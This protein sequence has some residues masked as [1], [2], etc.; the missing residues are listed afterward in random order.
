MALPI[1][2]SLCR[3]HA[4]GS[5]MHGQNCSY[6]H[7]EEMIGSRVGDAEPISPE[8]LNDWGYEQDEPRRVRHIICKHWQASDGGC[9]KG[10]QC[11]FAH[12]SNAIGSKEGEPNPPARDRESEDDDGRQVRYKLCRDWKNYQC[13]RGD[14]CPF[15]HGFQ[16]INTKAGDPN[17]ESEESAAPAA[18]L[19]PEPI[20]SMPQGWKQTCRYWLQGFCERGDS[21]SFAH[22]DRAGASAFSNASATSSAPA[23]APK[24]APPPPPPPPRTMEPKPISEKLRTWKTNSCKFGDTCPNILTCH[25][26]HFDHELRQAGERV[27]PPCHRQQGKPKFS[28]LCP[29]FALAKCP[30]GPDCAKAHGL[31][32]LEVPILQNF[33]SR[34]F[35]LDTEDDYL[36]VRAGDIVHRVPHSQDHVENWIRVRTTTSPPVEGW[37]PGWAIEET[38]TSTD[39]L[40]MLA[41]FLQFL[42]GNGGSATEGDVNIWAAQDKVRREYMAS[43]ID[44]SRTIT[45][46]RVTPVTQEAAEG[47]WLFS[48]E[49]FR[50]QTSPSKQSGQTSSTKASS[51]PNDDRPDPW[52]QDLD[53]WARGRLDQGR[54]KRK[55]PTS[56]TPVSSATNL[57]P[58]RSTMQGH[59]SS[60]APLSQAQPQVSLPDSLGLL[61]LT[62]G[63]LRGASIKDLIAASKLIAD[64]LNRRFNES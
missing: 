9:W 57:P 58:A 5:C 22:V 36:T 3:Y 49:G 2:R 55:A 59:A 7:G 28:S 17:R 48:L 44:F 63:H 51:T 29:L 23:A 19:P 30:D 40:A 37:V 43:P 12:G 46:V 35:D 13:V 61:N 41:D 53:P 8:G 18:S 25:E 11:S 31:Q 33:D 16:N 15:A 54:P 32:E 45:Q 6:A 47:S 26:A 62:P 4:A 50:G 24:P 20:P 38:D 1:R 42:E 27:P 39:P 56:N 34:D 52:D 60:R 10:D 64:E 14:S 21:C